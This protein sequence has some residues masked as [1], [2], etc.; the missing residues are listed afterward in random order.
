MF[1]MRYKKHFFAMALAL[2]T[3][4]TIGTLVTQKSADSAISYGI[5]VGDFPQYTAQIGQRLYTANRFSNNVSV[6]DLDTKSLVTNI[7]VGTTPVD[8]TEVGTDLYVMNSGAGT[9]SVINTLTNT[10]SNTI[11]IGT[12]TQPWEN[13]LVGSDLYV[14]NFASTT[15]SIIDTVTKTV[16]GSIT[17]GSGSK[18]GRLVGTKLYISRINGANVTVIDTITKTIITTIPAGA[19]AQFLTPVGS[20]LYVSN[21]NSNNITVIDTVSDTVVATVP[22]GTQPQDMIL[23]GTDLYVTH[24]NSPNVVI[25]NTLTNTVSNT[26]NVGN[27]SSMGV[28]MGTDLYVLN[29]L[30]DSVIVI[31]TLTQTI[32][33][34]VIVGDLPLDAE[35]IGTYL[36]VSNGS[37]DSVSIIDTDTNTLVEVGKPLIL[38][39]RITGDVL[40]LTYDEP[41][42]T[43]SIPDVADFQVLV[44]AVPATISLISVV[45]S[46]VV[47]TLTSVPVPSDTVTVSYTV[48]GINPTQD[49]TG[50]DA[51]ALI[52]LS[53]TVV[54]CAVIGVGNFPNE[55]IAVGTNLYVLNFLSASVSVINTLTNTVIDTI[56]VGTQTWSGAIVGTDLYIANAGAGTVSVIDT[57]VNTVTD[58]ISVGPSSPRA[59]TLVG[60]DLYVLKYFSANVTVIDTLTNTVTDTISV[61]TYP[62]MGVI[63][64]TDL[65]IINTLSDNVSVID[66]LTKTVTD[67]IGV[68]DSPADATS[69]GT[70]IYTTNG[71]ADTVSV[72][73]T[74]TNTVTDTISVGSLPVQVVALGT[75]LYVTNLSS[76]NIS[77]IDTLTN[78][79]IDTI[80]VGGSP[81]YMASIGSVLY[82]LNE[83]DASISVIDTT[84]NTVT[85]T[86]VVGGTA[87]WFTL[88]GTNLYINSGYGAGSVYIFDTTTNTVLSQPC[89][90][91]VTHT[92]TYTAG[93]FGSIT[94][95]S[96]QIVNDG[97]D[98]TPVTAV[99]DPGYRFTQWSDASTA[100]PRTDTGVT[101]NLSVTASFV[102]L[103]N[104]GS[105]GSTGCVGQACGDTLAPE[106][107]AI[108]VS[109][110]TTSSAVITWT[111]SEP[112][113]TAFY[114]GLNDGYGSGYRGSGNRVTSHSVTLTNLAEGAEYHFQL[115]AADERGN[116]AVT[117]D[118]VFSTL[119]TAQLLESLEISNINATFI[120]ETTAVINWQ[121]NAPLNSRVD[122][123]IS[124]AYGNVATNDVSTMSHTVNLS[125]LSPNST[126]HYRVTSGFGTSTV[127][128]GDFVFSTLVSLTPPTNP[129]DFAATGEEGRVRLTWTNPDEDDFSRVRVV[130]RPD[131]Y[132]TDM[133]D[134]A[135]VYE[136]D[137]ESA[138]HSSLPPTQ[139]QFYAIFAIDDIGGRS[140]GSISLATTLSVEPMEEP[141]TPPEQVVPPVTPP[142]NPPTTPNPPTSPTRPTAPTNPPTS[143]TTPPVTGLPVAPSTTPELVVP[144]VTAPDV[145]LL[146]PNE[147]T[148]PAQELPIAQLAGIAPT[149]TVLQQI[150]EW[151]EASP[152]SP[153]MAAAI[154]TAATL[155][156][157]ASVAN[158]FSY[159]GYLFSQPLM[160]I[161]AR[162][163]KKWGVVYNSITKQGTNLAVV[164]L[165]DAETGRV[166][167]TKITDNLGRYFFHVK[168]GKYRLEASKADHVFPSVVAN[169]LA[170]D[171]EYLDIYHGTPVTVESEMDLTM[172]I[173]LDPNHREEQNHIVLFNRFKTK[174]QYGISALSFGITAIALALQPSP[175]LLGLLLLQVVTYLAFRKLV[176]VHKPQKW[177]VVTEEGSSKSIKNA[178]VRIFDKQYNKL[179]ET[180]VT[181]SKGRYGFLANKNRYFVTADK[182]GY[183]RYVSEEIDL[184]KADAQTI[185]RPIG[186]R[187]AEIATPVPPSETIVTPTI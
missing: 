19:G 170:E 137:A 184:T 27:G 185:E 128:S 77:V 47:L 112:A 110:I 35:L 58:T 165:I 6:V 59:M 123:G 32:V 135:I 33:T 157:I 143:P 51:L 70:N 103:A 129:V 116:T 148:N 68:G 7:P 86:V 154:A 20:Y 16:T 24:F 138:Y 178:V 80:G 29:R 65:Y 78:T 168:P 9:V 160:L 151:V 74:L 109:D 82:V 146:K 84:T 108:L 119:T 171:D 2:V 113:T 173:P 181:D 10:V 56:G 147:L 166:L 55:S 94:G 85:D 152:I 66:T 60:T 159:L 182:Q 72:I 104:P 79:V 180:Q 5:T 54:D 125:G 164:R 134:G 91:P 34:T 8:L 149:T 17:V 101:A 31:D 98:G 132:P 141:E 179:L 127:S 87:T 126:Y 99:P 114:F 92:L 156:S 22:V 26:L 118:N 140:S 90:P 161:G 13:T 139:T 102:T 100:N 71:D 133:T 69:I 172:N 163:R 14:M 48:P 37:S 12:G 106:I 144:P 105:G 158:A 50:N 155:A 11:T 28:L 136:G 150:S 177:G 142:T 4:A 15:V 95:T 186:L 183:Q 83:G 63:M 1:F 36:Y 130:S 187:K 131:R 49:V 97:N 145:V 30:T 25:I 96:P 64:G 62:E 111:T 67:T 41:L 107:S 162:M 167:Q 45:G 120:T 46:E 61:G 121:T 53:V 122:Y 117:G 81:R 52:N 40:T 175:A 93:Q 43:A 115:Q 73:D 76:D 3:V 75:T 176:A 57:L 18:S 44:N 23:A 21:Q 124:D 88:V 153:E 89:V 169:G 42:D 39:A 174:M 38:T